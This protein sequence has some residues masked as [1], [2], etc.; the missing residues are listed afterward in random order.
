[1]GPRSRP[2]AGRTPGA[3][4]LLARSRES[5]R[6][7]YR[8]STGLSCW[9]DAVRLVSGQ[10]GPTDRDCCGVCSPHGCVSIGGVSHSRPMRTLDAARRSV[11]QQSA[12]A[13]ARE[14][15]G[16]ADDVRE[17]LRETH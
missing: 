9:V 1:M 15:R 14:Q 10:T 8:A 4:I 5:S 12:S 7:L 6:T 3:P 2:A 11:F 17:R 13:T 16:E